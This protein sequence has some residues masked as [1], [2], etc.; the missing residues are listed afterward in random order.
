VAQK[1]VDI[2]TEMKTQMS[3]WSSRGKASRYFLGQVTGFLLTGK[4]SSD[5]QTQ[6]VV[7]AYR[8]NPLVMDF[9]RI[10]KQIELSPA[11]VADLL[12]T[13]NADREKGT[14]F[15]RHLITPGQAEGSLEQELRFARETHNDFPF[16]GRIDELRKLIAEVKN[17][18]QQPIIKGQIKNL[19][20]TVEGMRMRPRDDL[21]GGDAPQV[22]LP[23]EPPPPPPPTDPKPPFVRPDVIVKPPATTATDSTPPPSETETTP[24][25][26]DESPPTSDTPAPTPGRNDTLGGDALR[27]SVGTLADLE[28]MLSAKRDEMDSLSELGEA[29]SL[30]L[31]MYMDN[32]SRLQS[33]LSNILKK[34]SDTASA[35]VANLK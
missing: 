19:N 25:A 16:A 22:Q 11:A 17:P 28:N 9:I 24:S 27:G 23:P 21:G 2:A 5:P 1:K 29:Q 4:N 30:R 26:A 34:W 35:I 15:F 3:D 6:L 13:D 7:D 32:I 10:A 20:E 33:T 8:K 31:Q 14:E 18:K 12:S